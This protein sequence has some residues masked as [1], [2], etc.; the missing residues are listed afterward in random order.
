MTATTSSN[1]SAETLN[2]QLWTAVVKE[3]AAAGLD[4]H[5]FS[6]VHRSVVQ[7]IAQFL[8][9][10]A[11]SQPNE[12]TS[13]NGLSAWVSRYT[14]SGKSTAP[15]PPPI[16][17]C[18][19]PGTGKTT[20]LYVLD[21]VLHTQF[22]L[23]DE[24]TS[25]M[26]KPSGRTHTVQKR[27]FN[28]RDLS[29][30]S[31]RKW[32]ELLHFYAWDTGKHRLDHK[33][34]R[35]FISETLRPMQ[36][37]F[38]DEVEMTGYAPTLPDLAKQGLLVVGTSNQTTFAQLETDEM[39]PL[40]YTVDGTD[41]R[42]GDPAD[43]I[44]RETDAAWRL[45]GQTAA[46]AERH[47][48]R[49][50]YRWLETPSAVYTLLDFASAVKAPLLETE[51]IRFI[52]MVSTAVETPIVL[53]LDNFSLEILR[54]DYNAIM[55]FVHLFDA[56]EQ[57]N[58]G[59]LVRNTAAPP[60]LSREALTHMKVTI[61]SARGITEEIKTKT[62]IGIDRCISRIGQ[63]GHRAQTVLTNG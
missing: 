33:A 61:Q 23:P 48:E 62:V 50:S 24:V 45:F 8:A 55:R 3:A 34:L 32:G 37:I 30:L 57:V 52:D 51:W 58:V 41:M 19:V 20:F 4:P 9:T 17:I 63:A 6:D 25:T 43:A 12:T 14:P 47:F 21:K 46:Q 18:G 42:A 10:Q 28:G 49:L 31:V 15:P 2:E 56:I 27:Q 39:R 40:I 44:V 11:T 60:E 38:A 29:L 26:T 54:T 5:K 53:L 35:R 36:I 59:V 22:G 16:I 7:D 1:E 13:S